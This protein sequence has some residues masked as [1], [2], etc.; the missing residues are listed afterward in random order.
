MTPEQR[1]AQH[2]KTIEFIR[3]DIAW[4]RQTGFSIGPGTRMPESNTEQLIERQEQNIAM[5]ERFIDA[6][7]AKL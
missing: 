7:K 4:L 2:E 1:I 5:Y 3:Q 6:L